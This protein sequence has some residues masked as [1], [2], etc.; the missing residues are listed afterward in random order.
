MVIFKHSLHA[1]ASA[2]KCPAADDQ[3]DKALLAELSELSTNPAVVRAS[4]PKLKSQTVSWT[5]AQVLQS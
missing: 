2:A 1:T 4:N 5:I 3:Q